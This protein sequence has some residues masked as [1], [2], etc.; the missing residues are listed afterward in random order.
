MH[1]ADTFELEERE[2]G[3]R[4]VTH[5]FQPLAD[6]GPIIG[7]FCAWE[8]GEGRRDCVFEG[9]DEIYASH[10]ARSDAWKQASG[11][12]WKTD[13]NEAIRKA[14]MKRAQ[15]SW[16]RR[17]DRANGRFEA[18]VAAEFAADDS[19]E[20]TATEVREAPA[21]ARI[22]RPS[23]TPHQGKAGS[24]VADEPASAPTDEPSTDDLWRQIDDW[25]A[26]QA[27]GDLGKAGQIVASERDRL[28]FSIDEDLD[29]AQVLQL[30]DAIANRKA[31]A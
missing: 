21:S 22:A 17:T 14:L 1:K 3:S 13:E 19:I 26:M 28:G 16:P 20:T 6:R 24:V 10:R 30:R 12:I 4:I 7:G 18:A 5:R 25:S 29:H 9:I 23:A 11:G 27:D 2:D 8:T 31:D 15:K